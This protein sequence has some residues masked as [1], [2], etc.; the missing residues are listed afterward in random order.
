MR[1]GG[2][3][4]VSAAQHV[5]RTSLREEQADSWRPEGRRCR[6]EAQWAEHLLNKQVPSIALPPGVGAHACHPGTR[7]MEA[8][9]SGFQDQPQLCEPL[10]Q[11]TDRL[12]SEMVQRVGRPLPSLAELSAQDLQSGKT[13]RAPMVYIF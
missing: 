6:A 10:P 8:G 11:E 5:Q 12:E 4:L 13:K 2:L 7:E 1:R 3:E 9:G